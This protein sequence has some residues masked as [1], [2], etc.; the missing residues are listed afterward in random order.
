MILTIGISG[1]TQNRRWTEEY[2]LHLSQKRAES[3]VMYI[4]GRGIDPGKITARGYG[5]SFLVNQCKCEP[6]TICSE[7]EHQANRR[8]E[9]RILTWGH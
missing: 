4:I 8:T 5:E 1:M 2:N 9:F 3:A 7:E 6:G